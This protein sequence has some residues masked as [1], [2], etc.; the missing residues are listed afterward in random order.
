[1]AHTIMFIME[2][3]GSVKN[4]PKTVLSG[5]RVMAGEDITSPTFNLNCLTNS[6]LSEN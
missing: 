5:D 2:E 4:L 3:E 1:M 6:T